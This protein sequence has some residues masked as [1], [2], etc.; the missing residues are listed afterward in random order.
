[1]LRLF[2]AVR[3]EHCRPPLEVTAVMLRST[4][5]RRVVAAFDRM[6]CRASP[7]PQIVIRPE[8]IWFP[9]IQGCSFSLQLA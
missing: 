7:P 5:R 4:H 6:S 3:V 8:E 1:M 9:Q 2:C